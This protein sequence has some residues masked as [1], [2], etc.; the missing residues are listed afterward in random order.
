MND[1]TKMLTI[2]MTKDQAQSISD[3]MADLLCWHGG[4]AAALMGTDREFDNAPMGIKGVRDAHIKIKQAL[5]SIDAEEKADMDS[6]ESLRRTRDG[7]ADEVTRLKKMLRG[8]A[9]EDDHE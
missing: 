1:K 9:L 4:F 8:K 6:I 5:A 2:T 7:L 3:S